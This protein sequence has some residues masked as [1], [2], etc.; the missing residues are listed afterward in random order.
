MQTGFVRRW[1]NAFLVTGVVCALAGPGLAA[2][3]IGQAE[4]IVNIVTARLGK[5]QEAVLAN[6]NAVHMGERIRSRA[7]ASAELLFND[8]T[9]LAVGPNAAVYLDKFVYSGGT[10]GNQIV[11]N[12]VR[13]AFRFASGK[14][15]S[16]S[17]SIKTPT[18]TVGVRGTLFDGYIDA[19]GSSV[20]VLLNGQVEVCNHGGG[21]I[22][23]DNPCESVRIDPSGRMNQ[24]ARPDP[25]LLGGVGA[26]AA[27]PF[28]VDQQQ[29][30]PQ[31]RGS[32]AVVR[33]CT[34]SLGVNPLT[35]PT[36]PSGG[37]GFDAIDG[38]GSNGGGGTGGGGSA[39]GAG[40]GRNGGTSGGSG[41]N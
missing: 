9:R 39:G 31:M 16:R 19:D 21:C 29:L 6:G 27:V 34:G 22:Q 28:L 12:A 15:G 33:N 7:G 3:R 25:N 35:G 20:I 32:A 23:L 8:Q 1:A 30:K 36:A 40:Q 10:S 18:S 26:Q 4:T 11:L 2:E 5:G 24:A 14:A 38:G 37:R 41:V 17:Y 13:G